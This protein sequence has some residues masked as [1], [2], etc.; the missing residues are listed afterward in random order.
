[1]F[2]KRVEAVHSWRR[3]YHICRVARQLAERPPLF[4]IGG[5]IATGS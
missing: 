3:R 5:G 2:P 1:M 4:A